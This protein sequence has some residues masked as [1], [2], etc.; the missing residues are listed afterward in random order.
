MCV[1]ENAPVIRVVPSTSS[2]VVQPLSQTVADVRNDRHI[3]NLH[4]TQS[5][6]RFMR[7]FILFAYCGFR[8]AVIDMDQVVQCTLPEV[9]IAAAIGL[10]I[11]FSIRHR[12]LITNFAECYEDLLLHAPC[13]PFPGILVSEDS[14]QNVS[15]V[16][17]TKGPKSF[18][19][20]IVF[21]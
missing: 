19:L 13:R 12:P 18:N 15:A 3:S 5:V 17:C 10:N 9:P 7:S 20:R 8:L 6:I 4:Q 14:Q 1:I 11:V 2:E 21:D 16:L